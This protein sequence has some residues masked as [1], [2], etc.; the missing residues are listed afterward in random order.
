MADVRSH[1]TGESERA[2][3]E[4]FLGPLLE[5]FECA[6][7][8]S[9]LWRH[10]PGGWDGSR[11]QGERE[12][13]LRMARA[14]LGADDRFQEAWEVQ[15]WGGWCAEP[16][17]ARFFPVGLCLLGL[18]AADVDVSTKAAELLLTEG[19]TDGYRYYGH[20]LGI[21]PDADDLGLALQLLPLAGDRPDLH[22]ILEHPIEVLLGNVGPDGFIHTYLEQGLA[23]PTTPDG[24]HWLVR[25]CPAVAA[26]ALIGLIVTDWPLPSGFRDRALQ[27]LLTVLRDEGPAS[28]DAY[29]LCYARLLLAHLEQALRGR[30]CPAAARAELHEM[31]SAIEQEILATEE[32]DGGWGSPLATACHLTVLSLRRT[33]GFD[34]SAAILYLCARQ[35]PDGLWPREALYHCPGRDN[36]QH[37]YATRSVTTAICME[38][39][40]LAGR[41]LPEAESAVVRGGG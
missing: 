6:L 24:P 11:V 13:A 38:A 2:I 18:A 7:A 33:R 25:R 3:V 34:P 23:E 9:W 30:D 36:S 21:P 4:Q 17:I 29:P 35:E 5:R 22:R 14:G 41:L 20:W 26:R 8:T 27:R 1:Y 10:M 16:R 31:L 37:D 15:R 40:A 28:V 32:L 12:R 19:R 39:L